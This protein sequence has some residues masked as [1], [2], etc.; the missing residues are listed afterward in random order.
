M[1]WIAMLLWTL[2]LML[3]GSLCEKHSVARRTIPFEDVRLNE[4][5]NAELLLSRYLKTTRADCIRKCLITPECL[6]VNFCESGKCQLNS[7]DVHSQNAVLKEAKRCR[8]LGMKGS[9][10]MN[11]EENGLQVSEDEIPNK[12][13]CK[14]ARKQ[15]ES[16]WSE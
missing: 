10:K 3:V 11:C 5:L 4:V 15:H 2:S 8:Y 6:S 14:I 1:K 12:S 9:G 16:F 7:Q 13:K